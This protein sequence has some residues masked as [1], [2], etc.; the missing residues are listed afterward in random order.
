MAGHILHLPEERPAKTA[1]TWTPS[2]VRRG[3]GRPK[4]TW[5]RTFCKDLASVD[6]T[7][8]E[9]ATVAADRL[10]CRQLAA[11]QCAKPHGR[12]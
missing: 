12:N 11:A 9:C 4:E 5:R 6:I 7:W 10:C 3:R 2:E 1:M 8:E